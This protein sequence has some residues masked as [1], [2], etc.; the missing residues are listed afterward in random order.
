M[1]K[2]SKLETDGRMKTG[3]SLCINEL[4]SN[5][6]RKK[7]KAHESKLPGMLAMHRT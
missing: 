4:M 2:Y 1:K 7:L 5:R 6:N 3:E